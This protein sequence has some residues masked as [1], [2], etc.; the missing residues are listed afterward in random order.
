M[1]TSFGTTDLLKVVCD[2]TRSKWSADS[3][4]EIRKIFFANKFCVARKIMNY[5]FRWQYNILLMNL[6]NYLPNILTISP[7]QV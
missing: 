6:N 7:A 5:N 3:F 1:T 2:D 4:A